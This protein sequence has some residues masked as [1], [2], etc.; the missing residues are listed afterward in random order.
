MAVLVILSCVLVNAQGKPVTGSG[1]IITQKFSYTNFDKL[2]LLDLDG[3][4]NVTIGKP[5]SITVAIDNNLEKL[6]D[7]STS[8]GELRI[9]LAGN[10]NNKL[11]VENTNIRIHI[12]MPEVSVIRHRSNSTLNVN[13]IAGRYLRINNG[14]NGTT[15]LQGSIDELD[16]VCTGNGT[17]Q[18]EELFAKTVKVNKSGNGNVYIKTDNSFSA[19]GSGNGNVVNKGEGLP[20]NN[21]TITGNGEIVYKNKPIAK[22]EPHIRVQ[23]KIKNESSDYT[24]LTVKYPGKGSYGISVKAGQTVHES[25]PVGTKLFKGGQ[26][27]TLKNTVYEVSGE[28]EQTFI[29]KPMY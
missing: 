4:I 14:G 25:F 11:Y 17:V 7:V 28:K 13:G 3:I 23:V 22:E 18:G 16:I 2:E 26:L 6:L 29:I 12:T 19:N 8:D 21:A 24:Q 20:N 27:T 5:F 9:K 15:V 1:N 10:T